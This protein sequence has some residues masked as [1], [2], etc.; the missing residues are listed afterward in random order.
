[1]TRAFRQYPICRGPLDQ[2]GSSSGH[3]T[4]WAWSTLQLAMSESRY[5]LQYMVIHTKID[6]KQIVLVFLLKVSVALLQNTTGITT[7]TTMAAAGR[8]GSLS[9]HVRP[10]APCWRFEWIGYNPW[11]SRCHLGGGWGCV[12]PSKCSFVL[13]MMNCHNIGV[14]W[15]PHTPLTAP[16]ITSACSG[17]CCLSIHCA[18]AERKAS[19][20]ALG[21][22]F[23]WWW[24]WLAMV[25]LVNVGC[26]RP[27]SV[28]STVGIVKF[29]C[30]SFFNSYIHPIHSWHPTQ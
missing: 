17:G 18:G 9:P 13:V 20:G 10:C 26:W 21:G 3:H 22:H 5:V 19:C 24:S 8:N 27:T 15:G 16:K 29:V 23:C 11:A 4:T 6:Y 28:R 2:S 30:G 14:F 1:M 7:A 25:V 12:W